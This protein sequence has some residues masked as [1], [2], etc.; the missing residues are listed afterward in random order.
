MS[1]AI[2]SEDLALLKAMLESGDLGAPLSHKRLSAGSLERLGEDASF[3]YGLDREQALRV[4]AVLLAERSSRR[5]PP[6]LVWTGPEG[7]NADSRDTEVVVRRLFEGATKEVIVAGYSFDHG[8]RIFAPL[9]EA[10]KSRGVKATFVLDLAG[11]A[12]VESEMDSFAR[13]R[14]VAFLG[15]NWPWGEPRPA[16]YYDPRTIT[17][18][19]Y[20]SMHAKCIIVD[21]ARAL[22]TSANFTSRAQS[23]NIEVGVLLEDAAFATELADH[24][25]E[26][27]KAEL[28]TR[29]HPAGSESGS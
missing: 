26:L 14:I 3:L 18:K 23:R 16:I 17:P 5:S 1:A 4:I 25:R 2:A 13:G 11:Q 27:L 28:L 7:A 12:R 20:A 22:V 15:K 24:W 6:E 29:Y 19:V 10:M 9:Y 8:E 21:D